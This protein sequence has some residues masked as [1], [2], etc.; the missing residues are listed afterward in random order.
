MFKTSSQAYLASHTALRKLQQYSREGRSPDGAIVAVQNEMARSG[1]ARRCLFVTPAIFVQ[2]G[3]SET[4]ATGRGWKESLQDYY[5]KAKK[6]T[7]SKSKSSATRKVRQK[8]EN[9]KG[10]VS[11]RAVQHVRSESGKTGGSKRAGGGSSVNDVAK[12]ISAM[13]RYFAK[14]KQWPTK[15][16]SATKWQ[17]STGLWNRAKA[18]QDGQ[19][20]KNSWKKKTHCS[21]ESKVS[22]RPKDH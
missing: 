9:W 10:K 3:D 20:A 11:K 17:V 16:Y 6:K 7:A 18:E 1:Q 13:Q 21:S 22:R 5:G 4:C 8:N 15:R 12:K 14:W 2:K 19:E